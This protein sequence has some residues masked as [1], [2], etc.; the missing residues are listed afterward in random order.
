MSKPTIAF[1]GATGGCINACLAH[2]LQTGYHAVALA[3]T[4]SK[5]TALLRTQNIDQETLDSRLRIVTGDATDPEAVKNTLLL[6]AAGF[7][8]DPTTS[9]SSPTPTPTLVS[10]IISGIGATGNFRG[11]CFE[12]D[13]P[14][15]CEEATR[16]LLTA[17]RNIYATYPEFM[18][19]ANV[20]S[21][22]LLTVLSGMGVDPSQKQ[23]DVPF[24]LRR[25]Y[26]GLLHVPHADKWVM[27]EMLAKREA[28]DL[29]RGVITVR[30]GSLLTGDHMLGSGYGYEKVR[31]GTE[32]EE[33][34]VGWTIPRADVGEWVFREVVVMG[35]GR[36][37]DEKVTLTCW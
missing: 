11:W 36:W 17:L 24:L 35:G 21:R 2:T 8:T 9:A 34:S 18:L 30:P 28:R 6:Q 20:K 22:P 23:M 15:I 19:P 10:H 37:L 13:Q 25:V 7:P 14:H 26:H 31:V 3:R 5:L 27:E 29:F 16:A 32:R 1:L 4:P 12:F 33:P